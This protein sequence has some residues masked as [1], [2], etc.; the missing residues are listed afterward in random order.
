MIDRVIV[1]THTGK[2]RLLMTILGRLPATVEEIRGDYV[3]FC[4]NGINSCEPYALRALCLKQAFDQCR[5]Y[6]ELIQ[7][8]KEQISL[9]DMKALSP[10]LK[11]ARKNILAKISRL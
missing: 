7:E 4:L 2:R 10:G 8:L 11:S 5:P 9:M 6:P 3:D 1:E